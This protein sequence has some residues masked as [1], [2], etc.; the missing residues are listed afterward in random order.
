MKRFPLFVLMML[1]ISATAFSQA[2][3]EELKALKAEKMAA[4]GDL[5]GKIATIQGEVDGIQADIDVL[6]GWRKGVSGLIGFSFTNSNNWIGNPNPESSSTALNFGLNAYAN[7]DSKKSFWNNKLIV[8]KSW[9][10]VDLSSGDAGSEDDGLFDNGTSDILNLSSLYGYKLSNKFAISGLG[11]LNTSIENFLS[12][13]TLD[14]GVGGTWTPTQNMT[15][16]IHPF[17][18]HVA[19][20]GV[21]GVSSEG[22]I[23]A[24]VRWDYFNNFKIASKNFTWNTTL[25]TFIPYK[26]TTPTLFEYTWLNGISFELWKGIGVGYNF[27][28][29]NAE[30]ESTDMQSYHSFGVTYAF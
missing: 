13:G 25:T 7:R 20:S 29:R 22:A 14:I 30:F 6:T 23:G 3:L 5:Q 28:I 4:I 11:E 27:G 9:Q 16:V 26:S 19:F 8:N 10:D 17:N 12:P 21:D 24:K 15:V 1:V 2:N 18:Y